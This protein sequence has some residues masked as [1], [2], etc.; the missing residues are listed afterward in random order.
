MFVAALGAARVGTVAAGHRDR[1]A[2]MARSMHRI[3]GA[4]G[5]LAADTLAAPP[6]PA[7]TR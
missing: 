4:S 6:A 3:A 1:E 7:P 5:S 2:P